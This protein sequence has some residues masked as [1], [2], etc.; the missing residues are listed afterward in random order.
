VVRK[1]DVD[2]VTVAQEVLPRLPKWMDAALADK[3][4]Q[5]DRI[6]I[7]NIKVESTTLAL[8]NFDADLKLNDEGGIQHASVTDGKIDVELTP[9]NNE[10]DITVSANKGWVSPPG[11]KLEF[12]DFSAKAIA[13][14]KQIRV[15]EFSALLYGGAAKGTAMINIGGPWSLEG[16][17]ATERINLQ[18]M[19]PAFTTAAKSSGQL[20]SRFRFSM[21]SPELASLFGQPRV[22]G[23]FAIRKGDLD[24]VDLVRAL[25]MGGRE[26]VQGGA[27][28]FEEITGTMALANE[29]YQFRNIKLGSGLLS[30]TGGF[31]VSPN[32]DI[33]GKTFVE[34]RSQ[35]AQIRGNFNINGS[36]KAIV[37]KPN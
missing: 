33:S 34:L 12:T 7:R 18:E 1:I 5:V 35:A 13:S 24:G 32:N 29:R 28:R 17:I 16:E 9:R 25:Q 6:S 23:N 36:L 2:S 30:A 3:T 31:E 27:T 15:S 20:E 37:L 21:Q 22:D 14:G 10:V 8:P 4:V 11:P 19:M 26:N